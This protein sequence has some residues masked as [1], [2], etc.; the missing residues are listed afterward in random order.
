MSSESR[1]SQHNRRT[2]SGEHRFSVGTLTS[3]R[4]PSV[5]PERRRGVRPLPAFACSAG[6]R[7]AVRYPGP[8]P[9]AVGIGVGSRG[10]ERG[11]PNV[12]TALRFCPLKMGS[13]TRSS[14]VFR[15]RGGRGD[16]RRV[17][18]DPP[19]CDVLTTG[20]GI[21]RSTA[22][23]RPQD[24]DDHVPYGCPTFAA[25][26][27]ASGLCRFDASKILE[28]LCGPGCFVLLG[29]HARDGGRI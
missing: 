14:T 15:I 26:G 21:A 1:Q 9:G 3:R 12:G 6:P 23:G 7:A 24:A 20:D 13:A 2:S 17:G 8:S 18:Q 22:C 29:Q 27:H 19:R 16:D 28:F 10:F 4:V 25:I 11:Q 5:P